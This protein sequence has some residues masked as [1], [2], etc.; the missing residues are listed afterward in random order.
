MKTKLSGRFWCA[1][2]ILS[3]MGQ[4][5]W[6]VENMYFNVFIYKMFHASAGDIS[7][8]VAA[9]AV[10]ATITTVFMGALSDKIGKRKLFICGGYILWGISIFS[11]TLL[12]TDILGSLFPMVT[13]AA[14][15]GVS[16]T[17][18]LDCVMTFFGSTANDAA[19]NAWLTDSTDNS[20]RGAAEGIN[21]MMP[22]AAI[23]VVFGGFMAFDLNKAESWSA[24]FTLIG[25]CTVLVGVLGIFVIK[26]PDIS[27]SKTGYFK[28]IIY[29]FK[30]STIKQN[31]RLYKT[32]LLFI[33]F[34]I[35]IQ[36]FMPYLILYYEVS[37]KMSN[38]VL[39]MAPAIIIASVVTAFWGRI[40]DKKGF[41][42]SGII[43]LISLIIGY[44]V[45]GFLKNTALV[46]VG[47]LLMMCGYLSAMAVFGAKIRD[48]TPTGKSGRLQGIRIFSQVLIPGVIGPY[49][50]KMVLSGAETVL[51]NDGTYSFIPNQNIFFA[52]LIAAAVVFVIMLF[53][54]EKKQ[55][56]TVTLTTPFEKD[57]SDVPYNF[58]PRPQ[59]K[60]DGFLCLNGKWDFSVLNSTG[61]KDMGKI[62]VPFPPESKVSGIYKTLNKNDTLIYKRYF[63]LDKDF[64]KGK[65]ILH[66]DAVD[67]EC[68]VFLN[69]KEIGSN[70]GGYLPFSFDVTDAVAVGENHLTVYVTDKTSL[71]LPYGKQKIKRGG[72]WYTTVSG[73]WQTV[74]LESLPKTHI[75]DLKI[76]TDT[77][78]VRIKTNGGD[79]NKQL[80]LLTDTGVKT[81]DYT[82]DEI[83]L[84]IENPKLWSPENPYLYEFSIL[85]GE[86]KISS[87]F[88]LRTV[89]VKNGEKY[90]CIAL[91]HKPYFLNGLLDQGYFSDGIYLPA[92]EK[93]YEFDILKMKELGFN[94]LRKHIK[95]EPD[96]F[97]YY[98]DKY[99]MIVLQ[100]MVN[101]GKYS[102]LIDTALATVFLK[103]GVKH[104][105]TDF[106]KTFFEKQCNDTVLHL[107][108]HPSV[109]GYTIFNEGWG[110]Y[111]DGS[112]LYK[113]L[114]ELDPTR[115]YDTASGW[116]KPKMSDFESEHIY[117]KPI[118]VKK[119]PRL[120]LFLSEFGGYSCKILNHSFN[121]DKTYG[122]GK[123]KNTADFEKALCDL[124][125][126]EVLPAVSKGLCA[127]VLTQVSD[128]EDETNGLVTYDRQVL[129]IHKN[130]L[131]TAFDKISNAFLKT[132]K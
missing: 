37:L 84:D 10:A 11:F 122:Y 47:S 56:K 21:A 110:Q 91:N 77:K 118:K 109:L 106:R 82:G 62:L 86:D 103:K 33:I 41:F 117:F 89:E 18:I 108:N 16:L 73:I 94:M 12:K 127:T 100:D 75:T 50:G 55:P 58:H 126:N 45:L 42:A 57:L 67:Q 72:M 5:A 64:N 92:N 49:I 54:K 69:G 115:V 65:L 53:T 68:T 39:I 97:Y 90:P 7:L 76:T 61:E 23:L 113:K 99:G 48:L 22:L 132:H 30:P 80:A 74:W 36:I 120:P 83:T 96:I 124:Y 35:S 20:N 38:Y 3:L 29:G 27:P 6:V 102:F 114:K 128:V 121:L 19:F 78:S 4:I 85:C 70:I 43:S 104:K 34:N 15:L 98:C 9:S 28:N 125:L 51:N 87:Y 66:F 26:D 32:L 17:I 40:Y 123:Y 105:A 24:I 52:A 31:L 59:M 44:A 71:E 112:H 14:S 8:M 107:Y 63:T 129:K 81:Y 13:S 79:F 116:Y 130:T 95:I 2:T 88:A 46:F 131:K 101:S 1:L 119:T 111:C 25:I 93:G 60:R